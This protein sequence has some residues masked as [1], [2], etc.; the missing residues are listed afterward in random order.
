MRVECAWP[1]L[2]VRGEFECR[3]PCFKEERLKAVELSRGD[4]EQARF[5]IKDSASRDL[6][7]DEA[8]CASVIGS[9]TASG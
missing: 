1:D 5:D 6:V 4:P 9:Y 7:A 8:V 2:R 3:T